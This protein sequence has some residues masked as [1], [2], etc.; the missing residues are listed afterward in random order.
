MAAARVQPAGMLATVEGHA[1]MTPLGTFIGA[2]DLLRL[3]RVRGLELQA[4]QLE[5]ELAD[6]VLMRAVPLMEVIEVDE[7]LDAHTEEQELPNVVE[8][9]RGRDL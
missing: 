4:H 6:Q 7:I 3:L 5:V 1:R 2:A 9:E 8:F